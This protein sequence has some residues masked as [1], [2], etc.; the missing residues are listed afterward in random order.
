MFI[1]QEAA[2]HQKKRG[3]LQHVG[4]T[5]AIIASDI[6]D[7]YRVFHVLE[8]FLQT[9]TLLATQ[10]MLQIPSDVQDRLIERLGETIQS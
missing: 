9:P 5:S 1:E 7:Q 2:E 4:A 3:Y 6:S 8:H 10:L